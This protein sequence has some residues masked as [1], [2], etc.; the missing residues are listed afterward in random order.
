MKEIWDKLPL[1]GAP[2]Q[3]GGEIYFDVDIAQ[4]LENATE[5]LEVGDITYWPPGGV[6]CIFFGK[7]P[8]STS[9]K[10]KP[11]SAVNVVGH[12]EEASRLTNHESISHIKIRPNI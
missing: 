1:E 11:A 12:L 6:L 3:W 8:I 7:T 9:E 4:D 2:V 10:P 5:D